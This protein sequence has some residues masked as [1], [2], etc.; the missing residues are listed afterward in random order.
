MNKEAK[1]ITKVHIASWIVFKDQGDVEKILAKNWVKNFEFF[2]RQPW[3]F[4]KYAA[5]NQK[6]IC[7]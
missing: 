4:S 1:V 7:F 5:G 3:V 6:K 2:P